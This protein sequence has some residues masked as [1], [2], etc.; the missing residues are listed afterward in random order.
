MNQRFFT[1]FSFSLIFSAVT[2]A[3]LKKKVVVLK[4]DC[5][6][7]V[8]IMFYVQREIVQGLKYFQKTYKSGIRGMFNLDMIYSFG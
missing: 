8:K 5:Q 4:E 2:P 6:Y 1:H 7:Q 3:E